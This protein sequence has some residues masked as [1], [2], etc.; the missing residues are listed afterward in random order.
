MP[1]PMHYLVA[2]DISDDRLLRKTAD[3]LEKQGVRI[4]KSVFMLKQT[5]EK[6]VKIQK[7]LEKSLGNDHYLLIIPLCSQCMNSSKYLGPTEKTF[8]IF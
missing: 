5:K 3:Y 7:H 1:R 4:Q 8:D 6:M 2:Y